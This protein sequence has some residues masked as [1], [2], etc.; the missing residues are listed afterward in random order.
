MSDNY[1]IAIILAAGNAS[2]FNSEIPK[3]FVEVKGKTILEYSLEAF[4]KNKNIDGIT[5]VT[6]FQF[7]EQTEKLIAKN[8]YKKV[9][10][11]L[12]GGKERF[13][14]SFVAIRAYSNK[15]N[16]NLIFHDA[17]RP[18]VSQRIID[19][20]IKELDFYNAVD[21]AIPLTDT[22]IKINEK[23]YIT[24]IPKRELFMRSQTPQAFNIET[25][26]YAY[27]LALN[28]KT[29]FA[30]DDCG[31]VKKYLPN[32]KIVVINGEERNFKVTFPEDIILMENF[33]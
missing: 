20:V 33:L 11:V 32:E 23:N 29:F 10:S 12:I 17:A 13:D 8:K 21:T 18:L 30:T 25:I 15:K 22:I 7:V 16:C 5:I 31:I 14:S 2:R 1:N 28:D 19:D 6:N 4:E 27:E 26:K 24:E 3:Q 9:K